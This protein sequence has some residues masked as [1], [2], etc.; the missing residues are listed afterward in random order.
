MI[1]VDSNIP[2]YLVGAD[3]PHKIDA[4]RSLERAISDGVKL[5]TDAETRR[6]SCTVE[7]Y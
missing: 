7:V 6:R 5:V 4:Q 1:L 2:M 3:H